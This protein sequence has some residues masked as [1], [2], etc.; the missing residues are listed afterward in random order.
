[1]QILIILL[2]AVDFFS[3]NVHR[4]FSISQEVLPLVDEVSNNNL[5]DK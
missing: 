4:C 2:V 1:V 5:S 3:A